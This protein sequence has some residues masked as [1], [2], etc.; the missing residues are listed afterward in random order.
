GQWPLYFI[1]N[2]GQVDEEVAFYIQGS[3]KSL[4]FTP[5]GITFALTSGA[6]DQPEKSREAWV[7]K[8]DFVGA[9]PVVPMAGGERQASFNYFK[10]QP[11]DWK[12]D[13]P[14]YNR[15]VY[16]DLW[17]GIDL[18][19][20]GTIAQMKYEFVV[21]PGADPNHIR[22]AYR[23]VSDLELKKTGE[24]KI[25]TP[26]AAIEDG[27]PLAYQVRKGKRVEVSMR[28]LLDPDAGT[29]SRSFRFDLG[30]FDPEL[31]LILDPVLHVY[32]GY[33]G[34]YV[35]DKGLGIAASP[36]G[37]AYVTGYSDSSAASFPV[38]V[39][40]CLVNS[41]GE[42]AFVAK[43]SV[44]GKGLEYC[45]YIGGNSYDRGNAIAVDGEGCAY[46]TGFTDSTGGTFPT[47]VGPD[48]TYN[49]VGDAFIAK[50]SADGSQLEYC[51]Y[52]GGDST[53]S[54]R[55]IGVDAGGC[56]YITGDTR[57]R[58]T[59]FPVKVGPSLVYGNMLASS[60]VAKINAQGT[61]LDF[62]GYIDHGVNP[63]LS[64]GLDV[65]VDSA[66]A[67]YM[68]GYVF[69]PNTVGYVLKLDPAGTH[70]IY[71]TWIGQFF[72]S[73][74]TYVTAIA[75]DAQGKAYVT[76]W[77]TE[78]ETLFPVKVGPDLT[79][80]GAADAYV[81]RLME[82]GDIEYCGYIG[83]SV[84][85]AGRGIAVDGTGRAMITGET[86]S[87]E[88]TFP[89]A[90]GPDSFFNGGAFDGFVA[91]VN[92]QGTELDYCGYVGGDDWD[93]PHG[94]ATDRFGHAYVTGETKSD[95]ASFPVIVGPDLTHNSANRDFDAFVTRIA[96]PLAADTHLVSAATGGSVDLDLN[97]SEDHAFRDYVILGSVSGTSPGFPLPGGLTLPLNWDWFTEL[98]RMN[99]NTGH[100]VNFMARLDDIGHESAQ[101]NIP[102]LPSSWI[103]IKM[104]FAY[105]LFNP[106]DFVS[107]PLEFE[108]VP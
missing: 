32:C 24:L 89:V 55:G 108:V 3:D 42:D 25:T 74:S 34:G 75:V 28:Y 86:N 73:D 8:Q 99:L 101:L 93:Y 90:E 9:R 53:E 69:H 19:Y 7:V 15:I 83:G 103:G 91:R 79:H 26:I 35:E 49:G 77:T 44:D 100:F 33:I 10:G 105:T 60:Y 80:N 59:T 64:H 23:G 70:L 66:C 87:T 11:H 67:A 51:G 2:Q 54:G 27:T 81:A 82:Q 71:N 78:D 31:P 94:I 92:A 22:L 104:H 68:A 98:I 46:V 61:D 106:F 102:T 48:L 13:V 88:A 6:T 96:M 58:E 76:G 72:G 40:P 107:N 47:V 36:E 21:R 12:T 50:L 52:V 4:F 85:D 57:S 1:E 30:A 56:A 41:G 43:V 39:G 29:G 95:Q 17:P 45:G 97:A 84:S 65:A 37:H 14:A 5:S 20:S 16:Q 38:K 62:C 18:V 63:V